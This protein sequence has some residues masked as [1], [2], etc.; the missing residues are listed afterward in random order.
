MKQNYIGGAWVDG[1]STSTNI[2]PSNTDDIIG[3]YAQAD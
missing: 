3:H 2:N 1:A